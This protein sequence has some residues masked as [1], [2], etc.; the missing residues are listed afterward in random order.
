[1][2][3]VSVETV[4]ELG[5]SCLVQILVEEV[6]PFLLLHALYDGART[7]EG[8][9]NQ[10]EKRPGPPQRFSWRRIRSQEVF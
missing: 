10:S 7:L 5:I 3:F 6:F 1:M 8:L 4:R 9:A 2:R